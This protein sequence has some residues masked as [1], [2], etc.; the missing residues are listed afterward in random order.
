M[1]AWTAHR[2]DAM[3]LVA[4]AL[5]TMFLIGCGPATGIHDPAMLASARTLAV[6]PAAGAPGPDGQN[7]GPMQASMLITSLSNL[8]YYQVQGPGQFR[9][10]LA[11]QPAEG[12]PWNPA[13]QAKT[14][15]ELGIDLLVLSD[16][17][18]YRFTKD[19]KSSYWVVGSSSWTESTFYATV[20]LRLVD[21]KDGRVVY[22][23]SGMAESK[24]GYGPAIQQANEMALRE[25]TDFVAKQPPRQAK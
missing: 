14:A 16:L 9:R 2:F 12:G 23:G 4:A 6:F 5:G 21:P 3:C 8:Q 17:A 19:N 15:A 7:A 18:D 22:S 10:A 24:L 25:L 11:S 13:V 20:N 1:R